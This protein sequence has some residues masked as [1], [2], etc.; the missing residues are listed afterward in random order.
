[1]SLAFALVVA[2][3]ASLVPDMVWYELGRRR[4]GRVLRLLCRISLEPDSCVRR[5]QRV[6]VKSGRFAWLI[7]K[8]FPGL[9]TIAP[10]LARIIGVRRPQFIILDSGGALLWA[11]SWMGVGYLFSDALDLIVRQPAHIGNLILVIFVAALV[12]YIG[13][14]FLQRQRFLRTLRMARITVEELKDRLDANDSDFIIVDTRSVLDVNTT[15]YGIPGAIWITAE[16]IG[17]RY[18]EIP[19]DRESARV[20]LMLKHNGISRVRPL[21]GGLNLWM[22]RNSP[23]R[24]SKSRVHR[25]RLLLLR[26]VTE[27]PRSP[28]SLKPRQAMASK[29]T[30]EMP[31]CLG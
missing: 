9:S 28:K 12:A 17:R 15:P 24:N 6:F 7:A 22:D 25:V 10:P 29:W 4:G 30:Y 21:Q 27:S 8:F 31:R 5:T 26:R 14:K 3:F 20:A 13:Y 23:L 16:D 18:H 11:G 2:L 1:M 19:T